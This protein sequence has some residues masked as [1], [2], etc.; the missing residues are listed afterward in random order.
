MGDCLSHV[1][2]FGPV[3]DLRPVQGVPLRANGGRE[4]LAMR[5]HFYLDE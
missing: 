2:L 5:V 4:G 1:S 3:M